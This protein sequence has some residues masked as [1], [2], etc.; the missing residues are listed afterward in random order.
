MV[1]EFAKDMRLTQAYESFIDFLKILK[2]SDKK[3][4]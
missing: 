3:N 4:A 2:T 1:D